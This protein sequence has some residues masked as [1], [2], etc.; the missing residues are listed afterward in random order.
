MLLLAVDLICSPTP[1]SSVLCGRL[2]DCLVYI[3]GG[4]LFI[5]SRRREKNQ[6]YNAS[7]VVCMG[8]ERQWERLCWRTQGCYS[9]ESY[10]VI[11]QIHLGYRASSNAVQLRADT[12]YSMKGEEMK[13]SRKDTAVWVL[14]D[15]AHRP[16]SSS[17]TH[18]CFEP[19][20][21]S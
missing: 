21:S 17:F 15:A 12:A 4:V 14:E 7:V 8:F 3:W 10:S 18:H 2:L 19:S 9:R 20:W 13:G 16:D 1:I 5:F 11:N 6:P